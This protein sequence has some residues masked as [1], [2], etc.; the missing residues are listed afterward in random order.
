MAR[1]GEQ[2]I[3]CN[4]NSCKFNNKSRCC[5]LSDIIVGQEPPT[6]NAKYKAD[7]ICGSF[8]AEML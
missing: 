5:T 4:V 7:T 2:A 3:K 8:E 6:T 1:L